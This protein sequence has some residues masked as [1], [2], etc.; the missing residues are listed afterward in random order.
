MREHDLD[1][2]ATLRPAA[3]RIDERE[4]EHAH[5]APAL[6][7]GRTDVL[8]SDSIAHLQRTAGNAAV[9]QRLAGEEAD[10]ER[11]PVHD[12]VGRGG[13][14]PLDGDTRADMEARLGADFS[15]VRIH[16]DAQAHDSAVAVN[17]HAYTVG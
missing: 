15:G 12:V 17:A 6:L 8:N 5:A 11:S 1:G 7:G 14:R 16:D 4:D 9:A 13:G 3:A 10:E 2:I